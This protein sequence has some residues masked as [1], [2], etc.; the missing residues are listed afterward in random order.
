MAMEK[1]QWTE[2]KSES[3]RWV[4]SRYSCRVG[5]ER[6]GIQ[7]IYIILKN[8]RIYSSNLVIQTYVSSLD[9]LLVLVD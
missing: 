8:V 6:I 9:I 2:V 1:L 7:E 4:I 5:R 3:F